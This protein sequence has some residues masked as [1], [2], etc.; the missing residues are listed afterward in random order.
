MD[1]HKKRKKIKMEDI[2]IGTL[3]VLGIVL[4]ISN[5]MALSLGNDLKKATEE[6]NEKAR[7]GKISLTV[8]KNSKCAE[9]SDI[10]PA[11]EAIRQSKVN[12][13]DENTVEF[14]SKEAKELISKY[15]LK[16]IPSIVITG[17]I[18][19]VS[20]EGLE[21]KDNALIYSDVQPPY[22]NAGTGKTEGA[23][24]LY[25]IKDSSCAECKD[26][27]AL[28]TQIESTGVKFSEEKTVEAS[29]AE[30]K[31]LASKYR[32]SSVPSLI[33]SKDI[34]LYPA[35]AEA[36]PQVGSIEQDGAFVLRAPYPPF[37]NLTTGKVNGVVKMTYL[38]DLSCADCYD[39]N[40]HK[41][42]LSSQGSFGITI[43]SEETVD[44]SSAKGKELVRKYGIT[45]VPTIILSKDVSVYP[46]SQG[47]KQFFKVAD[48]GSYFF[49]SLSLMGTFKDLSTGEIV[50][51]QA[52]G[53]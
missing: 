47:L 1:E 44:I 20:L 5:L 45:L 6:Y 51:P 46:S 33:L 8:I 26:L 24:R 48:D 13:T 49:T 18:E 32:L 4:L 7:P 52:Q 31:E 23:V 37:K 10:A 25:L 53:Q 15:Q 9:C 14:N 42:V 29:S 35:I 38:T 41:S 12:V 3:V 11:V 17:E 16:K 28:V 19:R 2:L 39:V 21:K 30:G 34:E 40:N 43:S 27:S 50:K 22:T 36:W